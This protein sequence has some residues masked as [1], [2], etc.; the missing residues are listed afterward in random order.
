MR[1]LLTVT[2]VVM[3]ALPGLSQAAVV[4]VNN[5]SLVPQP[6]QVITPVAPAL[7]SAFKQQPFPLAAPRATAAPTASSS[8]Q[9]PGASGARP[10]APPR[11][12]P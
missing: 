7:S 9:S 12:A 4:S 1:K 10:S 5:P 3:G 6:P 8:Q 11:V 2:A